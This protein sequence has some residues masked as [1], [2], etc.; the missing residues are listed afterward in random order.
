M[1]AGEACGAGV[2][3]VLVQSQRKK[4]LAVREARL[5]ASCAYRLTVRFKRR[6]GLSRALRV[7]AVF[8]GN[9]RLKQRRAP[10]GTAAVPRR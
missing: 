5:R 10:L 8:R 9:D 3:T 6:T 7:R 4:T 2:F 1:S